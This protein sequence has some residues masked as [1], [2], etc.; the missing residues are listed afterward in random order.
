MAPQ[1]VTIE[2]VLF[3]ADIVGESLD[4]AGPQ[5]EHELL[6]F[7]CS[8]LAHYRCPQ[9]VDFDPALPRLENG[10]LYKRLIKDRYWRNQDSR[11]L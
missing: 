4:E 10:K 9:S 7:C 3:D 5:L 8:R 2:A 11:I 6:E 1:P